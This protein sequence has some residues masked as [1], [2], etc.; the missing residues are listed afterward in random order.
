MTPSAALAG[1]LASLLLFGAWVGLGLEAP[2]RAAARA[3]WPL[4]ALPL[5]S[6]DRFL[7]DYLLCAIVLLNFAC[8][9]DAGFAALARFATLLRRLAS[10]TF[11]LYLSHALVIG[12]WL[13]LYPHDQHSGADALLL[14]LAIG[15]ATIALGAVTAHRRNAWRALFARLLPPRRTRGEP[16]AAKDKTAA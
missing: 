6:A 11:T 16:A 13:A 7:A 10:Y 14:G 1:W 9:R 3:W 2:R 5:G 12:L 4:P 8:A 15:A